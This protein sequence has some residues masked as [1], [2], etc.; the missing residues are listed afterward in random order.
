MSRHDEALPVRR[1]GAMNM[2]E[3]T[4]CM[5]L[6]HEHADWLVNGNRYEWPSLE[7]PSMRVTIKKIA[8]QRLKIVAERTFIGDR[9]TL[10]LVTKDDTPEGPLMF[11]MTWTKY[12]ELSFYINGELRYKDTMRSTEGLP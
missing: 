4:L 7:G 10:A 1:N 2:D 5:V 6:A 8:P 9:M 12:G 11:A 3:G